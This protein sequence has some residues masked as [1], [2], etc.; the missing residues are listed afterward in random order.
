MKSLCT[1]SV[2]SALSRMKL[3]IRTPLKIPLTMLKVFCLKHLQ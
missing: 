1:H 2:I 3:V